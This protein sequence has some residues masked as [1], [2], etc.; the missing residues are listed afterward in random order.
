M[1]P[2]I[3]SKAWKKKQANWHSEGLMRSWEKR[4]SGNARGQDIK[5]RGRRK[6][7]LKEKAHTSGAKGTESSSSGTWE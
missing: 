4:P 6:K 3:L 5:K 7:A 2:S 1:R